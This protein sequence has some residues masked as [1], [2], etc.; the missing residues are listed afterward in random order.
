VHNV[1][2]GKWDKNNQT[3]FLMMIISIDM[4][5]ISLEN[6]FLLETKRN[7]IM[8]GNFTKITYSNEL[9]TMNGIY[10]LCPIDVYSVEKI[11]NK[12]Q[13]RLNP[14]ISTN[15]LLIQE[16]SKF[17]NRLLD[18]YRQSRNCDRKVSNLLS[19]QLQGGCIKVYK[20]FGNDADSPCPTNSMQYVIKISGI[21]ES[22]EEIGLTYKLFEANENYI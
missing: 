12:K 19:K 8:N 5:K 13:V 14:S 6:I 20:D 11:M 7:N 4:Q 17:E 2:R 18:Y 1:K 15:S 10:V 21:W 3:L 22:P 9:F 16:V